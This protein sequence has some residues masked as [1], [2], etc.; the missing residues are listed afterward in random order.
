M[1]QHIPI[2]IRQSSSLLFVRPAC[3]AIPVGRVYVCSVPKSLP[4]A[5]VI[6]ESS[7]SAGLG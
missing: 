5:V 4:V 3:A 2:K 6:D 1:L 7:N